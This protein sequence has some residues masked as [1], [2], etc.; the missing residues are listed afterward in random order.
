MFDRKADLP[1]RIARREP[2]RTIQAQAEARGLANGVGEATSRLIHPRGGAGDFG[3][4]PN[5]NVAEIPGA[6]PQAEVRYGLQPNSADGSC[7]L[8]DQRNAVSGEMGVAADQ[9]QPLDLGLG[10]QQP[11]ERITM[12][13]W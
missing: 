1:S 7:W 4:Q 2:K 6:V 13:L 9:G 10:D 3:F 11:V 8:P 12:P 5:W